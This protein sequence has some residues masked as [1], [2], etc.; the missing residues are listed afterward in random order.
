MRWVVI[1]A[2]SIGRRHLR[3]LIA[4]GERDLVAVRRET[5]ALDE[6]LHDVRVV[7]SLAEARSADAI[8]IVCT[9]T[10]RHLDDA[11]AALG[12]GYH[13]LVEKPLA[14]AV[15]RVD[16]LRTAARSAGRTV[17]VAHCFRFHGLLQLIRRELSSG[18]IGR[19]QTAKVWCG[20]HLADW[21]PGRDYRETYSARREDGGGVLLDLVH[22][23]DYSDWLFGPA[24]DVSAEVRN[25]G[26]LDIDVEDV[27]D[28]V[29][30]ADGGAVVSC[31][32]DYL[33]RPATR[34]GRAVGERGTI[35]WDLIGGTAEVNDGHAS[36]PLRLP[37]G[38]DR[39]D[40][41][42]DELTAFADAVSGGAPFPVGIDAGARAVRI[43]LAAR[44]SASTGRRIPL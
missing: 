39:E 7:R 26:T 33:A 31:H 17:G 35:A 38:W 37:A 40:M 32:L 21:R 27:A 41:Y 44:E 11:L 43:A 4:R 13:V 10:A 25:T 1:G 12:A 19:P 18:R 28:V 24:T 9:P 5:G 16:E 23:L 36:E 42:R 29:L 3:N 34:G 2:G 14:D 6:D 22:E 30:R 20:Q 8:A 15:D